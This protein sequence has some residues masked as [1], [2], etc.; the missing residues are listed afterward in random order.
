MRWGP[1]ATGGLSLTGAELLQGA[2]RGREV[3][4]DLEGA[5]VGG[6]CLVAAAGGEQRFAQAVPD[7]GGFRK[8]MT[9][10]Q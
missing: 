3:R 10:D 8:Q 6:D 9:K 1:D 2:G 7:V 5:T 4:V